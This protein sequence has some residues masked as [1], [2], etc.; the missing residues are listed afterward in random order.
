[1]TYNVLMGT[2]NPIQSFTHSLTSKVQGHTVARSP[3]FLGT[4]T[5][6]TMKSIIIHAWPIVS[7]Y[8]E[9]LGLSSRRGI[10]SPR[11]ALSFLF[12]RCAILP[13]IHNM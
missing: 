12:V 8:P 5:K 11:S 10:A 7:C 13:Y 3:A 4:L 6:P 2:L 9:Q 1:M